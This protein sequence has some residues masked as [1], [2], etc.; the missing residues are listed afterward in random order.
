MVITAFVS[1]R[2]ASIAKWMREELPARAFGKPDV[3]HFFDLWYIGKSKF[4]YIRC[5]GFVS[6]IQRADSFI[7]ELGCPLVAQKLQSV[8]KLMTHLTV[9]GEFSS[10][11]NLGKTS[12][13]PPAQC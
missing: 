12:S 3:H 9:F 1:D 13:L 7:P 5:Y 4:P 8:S 6:T 2:H 11:P 10:I